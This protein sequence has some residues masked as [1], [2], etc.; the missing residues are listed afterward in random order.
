[1]TDADVDGAHIRTLL[2][3]FFF[4]QMPQLIDAGYIYIAQPPLYRVKRGKKE[5]YIDTDK[6]LDQYLMELGIENVS[7]VA[8]NDDGSEG[9]KLTPNQFKELLDKILQLKMFD[10]RLRRRNVSFHELLK[11]RKE[12]GQTLPLY[13]IESEEGV[14]F[15]YTEKEY[16]AMIE[17]LQ[18]DVTA[19]ADG[20][21]SEPALTHKMK[22][23]VT[24][25]FEVADLEKHIKDLEKQGIDVYEHWPEEEDYLV[26]FNAENAKVD[27]VELKPIYQ[28]DEKGKTFKLALLPQVLEFVKLAG[29]RGND[30]QRYK[31]L[32]EM[33]PDQLWNTTMD[34]ETRTILQVSLDD[35][36]EA[37][38]IFTVLMGDAVEPRRAFIQR[39]A[40]EVQFL[41]I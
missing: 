8:L 26:D 40:P 1:M 12:S 21:G 6:E 10:M 36:V 33:N 37:E 23:K 11:A 7:C 16:S 25:F 29:R 35:A 41:D 24:E 15:A 34:P 19:D 32:G 5:K 30:I 3:T 18:G 31:G 13:K 14:R 39:H 20:N 28:L 27:K 9:K 22:F 4:R 38:N 17:E 2:L